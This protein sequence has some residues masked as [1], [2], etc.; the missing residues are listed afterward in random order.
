M[1]R[2]GVY[3]VTSIEAKVTP[4]TVVCSTWFPR[5]FKLRAWFWIPLRVNIAFA[6]IKTSLSRINQPAEQIA[7]CLEESNGKNEKIT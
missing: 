7:N 4:N 2:V 1:R 6:T 3:I 5:S